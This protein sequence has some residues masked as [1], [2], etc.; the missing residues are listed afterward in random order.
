MAF[1]TYLNQAKGA[2]LDSDAADATPDSA[3]DA[4]DAIALIPIVFTKLAADAAAATVQAQTGIWY[5]PFT[6]S[7]RIDY[8][9]YLPVGTATANATNYATLTVQSL[10]GAA[11]TPVTIATRATDTVSTDDM[12]AAT[13]WDLVLSATA[14]NRVVAAGESIS[15]GITKAASGIAVPAGLLILKAK[16]V[17]A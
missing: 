8:A 11:G 10:D 12:A 6:C 2:H 4:D 13:Y 9:T 17:S 15:F 5:N 1:D 14:A 3:A 16:K 7:V